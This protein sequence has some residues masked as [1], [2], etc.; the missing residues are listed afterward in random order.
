[1]AKQ[2]NYLHTIELTIPDKKN[3]STDKKKSEPNA[4]MSAKLTGPLA[5]MLRNQLKELN[6]NPKNSGK[7]LQKMMEESY[8][9]IFMSEVNVQPML[10]NSGTRSGA[11]MPL[12]GPGS[13]TTEIQALKNRYPTLYCKGT[14]EGSAFVFWDSSRTRGQMIYPWCTDFWRMVSAIE[15]K[16]S[17]K[18]SMD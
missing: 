9:N 4:I 5:T 6:R 12:P 2:R 13:Q 14:E 18:C 15:K 7:K 1:M 11:L 10:N 8:K 17:V 3:S 16:F